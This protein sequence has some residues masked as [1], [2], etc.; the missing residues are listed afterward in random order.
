V[1]VDAVEAEHN[2]TI[3]PGPADRFRR[4]AAFHVVVSNADRKSSPCLLER[5]GGQVWV[6]YHGV[7]FHAE[8]KLRTVIWDFAGEPLPEELTG[9]LRRLGDALAIGDLAARLKSLLSAEEVAAM[10]QRLDDLLVAGT[11]PEPP[12]DRRSFPWPP[13]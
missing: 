13:V 11:F 8:P 4:V 9:D 10:R 7:C 12:G 2:L 6:V 5:G 1:F 3:M